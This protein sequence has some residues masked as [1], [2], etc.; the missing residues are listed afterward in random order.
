MVAVQNVDL[1][2]CNGLP[3]SYSIIYKNLYMHIG[4]LLMGHIYIEAYIHEAYSYIQIYISEAV[5]P[6]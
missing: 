3:I 5:H 2:N 4:S 1:V 6:L